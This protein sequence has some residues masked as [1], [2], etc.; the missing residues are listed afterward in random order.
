MRPSIE[1]YVLSCPDCQ[2][3]KPRNKLKPGFLHSLPI[4]DRIWTDISM[5]F[6]VGLPPVRGHD[7]MYVV[8]D[9][10]SKYAHFIPRSSTVTAEGVAQL[11]I[12]HVW[13][14]HGFPKSIITD[15]DPKFVSAFWRSLVQQLGIDHNMSTANHPE[16]DGQ[17]ERT[18]RTLVQYLRLYT[19]Q[20]TPN[21]L[22]SLACAKWVYN[23]TVH[24]S[25]RCS[26]ASLVYTETPLADAPLDLAVGSQPRQTVASDF[27]TQLA[28]A[29]ECMREEQERQARNY[30]KR[31]SAVSFNPGDLVLVDSHALLGTQEGEQPKKFAT[32]WVGPFAV[33]SRVNALAYIIDLPPT[34]RCHHTI[35]ESP[36][37]P[38]TLARKQ[39]Q[40]PRELPRPEDTVILEVR[41]TSRR[42]HRKREYYVKWPGTRDPE[43]VSEDRLRE[44][45]PPK[46]LS[47]LLDL[48]STTP[49]VRMQARGGDLLPY[50]RR[51][52]WR[53]GAADQQYLAHWGWAP[54]LGLCCG[55]LGRPIGG[56][57]AQRD[58]RSQL[59]WNG[60]RCG[61]QQ[62]QQQ[63]QQHRQQ[64]Q[65]QQQSIKFN[66][67]ICARGRARF[68]D[69]GAD[70]T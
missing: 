39:Q 49:S 4:P 28:A 23:T 30:D 54:P 7:S 43:W 62:R 56:D 69:G 67:T 16:A 44:A 34:W 31:R 26:P 35:N 3:Q 10:L 64:Q 48:A 17:T 15:R 66:M 14:L 68:A 33:R 11:F 57:P 32:R 45:I 5:D 1:E 58:G 29:K 53:E 21:W 22:D 52:R 70:V 55:F 18:N 13:K 20:N 8:V 40:R 24:S 2:Q 51:A 36:R 46:Q 63:R 37:F 25:T 38:R 12:N 9:R 19:Q 42:G 50:T 27:D 47:A 65:Q 61:E 6:I 59:H 41:I 60:H